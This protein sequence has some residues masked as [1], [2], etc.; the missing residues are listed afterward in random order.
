MRVATAITPELTSSLNEII[1][2]LAEGA[3]WHNRA[4]NQLRK[5][6]L[7]G[8]ARLS[9]CEAK[10][11]FCARQCLEK[12]LVDNLGFI[13]TAQTNG[14]AMAEQYTLNSLGD[15]KGYF[16]TWCERE[17]KLIKSLNTAINASRDISIC[18]Y[19]KLICLQHEVQDECMRAELLY[20]RLDMAQWAPHDIGVVS[21]WLHD[22]CENHP[23]DLDFNVG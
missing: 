18:I 22:Y 13:A 6:A 14:S 10:D 11:D 7:R 19:E 12:K 3:C 4:A 5:L 2:Y 21:K 23:G 16:H 8:F 15:L 20:E 9:D 17:Q 1:S